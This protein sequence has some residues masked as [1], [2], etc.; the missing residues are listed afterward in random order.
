MDNNKDEKEI[1]GSVDILQHKMD[2]EEISKF[3][4]AKENK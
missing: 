2:K 3:K 1:V 4:C